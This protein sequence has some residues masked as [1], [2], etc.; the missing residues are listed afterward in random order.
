MST[1]ILTGNAMDKIV[2]P[3]SSETSNWKALLKNTKVS[4][5][6]EQGRLLVKV[7][8]FE[9]VAEL[10]KK[11]S[12][13]KILSAIVVDPDPKV[14][15]VGFVDVLD[16]MV[17]VIDIADQSGRDI[18]K[19]SMENL[20]WEGQCFIRQNIGSLV[21]VSRANPLYK[22]TADSSLEEAVQLM[23][24]EVH[25]LAVLDDTTPSHY[26]SNIIS[27]SDIINFIVSK[28][29]LCGSKMAKRINEAGLAPLGVATVL[30][31]NNVI[32]VLRYMRD[33]KIGG[34]GIVDSFGRLVAN[35]SAT[36]LLGLTADKF[37]MLALPVKEFLQRIHGSIK[38]PVVTS[39][40]DTIANLMN[41]FVDH[42]IH[43]VYIVDNQ[44]IPIGVISMTDIMQFLL[45]E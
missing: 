40:V 31:S 14:G 3:Q 33:Y 22:I 41:K 26:I 7:Q 24:A 21:N 35:F 18:T 34:V 19:E 39:S 45:A 30:E 25:R 10:L 11:M 17:Y 28:G 6:L 20:K 23:A 29:G 5:I 15:V 2:Q 16:L 12:E 36:D 37:P 32:A 43:R 1:D 27:Q 9:E 4:S 38:E 8:Y 44:M 13:A 42:K